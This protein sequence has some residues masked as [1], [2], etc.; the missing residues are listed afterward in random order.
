MSH[1]QRLIILLMLTFVCAAFAQ[2][3]LDHVHLFQNFLKDATITS[4]PYGEGF[5]SYSSHDY[6]SLFALGAQ[7]GYGINP[8]LE[9]NA[10]LGFV[11][12][13]PKN[14]D[15]NSGLT[16]LTAAGRYLVYDDG[17]LRIAAGG[18]LTLPIGTDK[19]GYGNFDFG[20]FGAARYGLSN[21]MIVTGTLG[22]DFYDAGDKYHNSLVLAGGLIYPYSPQLAIIGELMFKTDVDYGMLSA[23]VDYTLQNS[24]RVRGALGLGIDN[25]APDIML[26]LSYLTTI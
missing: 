5:L 2:K 8:R 23:G 25:G 20:A 26:M 19:V 4:A 22:L 13:S 12:F 6:G 17:A 14:G 1:T 9:V 15:G 3:N 11:N 24:G 16:D 7:G 18:F 10:K 21:D